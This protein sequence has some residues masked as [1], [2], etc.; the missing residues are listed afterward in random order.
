MRRKRRRSHILDI[1]AEGWRFAALVALVVPLLLLPVTARAGTPTSL[2]DGVDKRLIVGLDTPSL[3]ETLKKKDIAPKGM[4]SDVAM[5]RIQEI[6]EAQD[7]LATS[8][9]KVSPGAVVDH[10][11]Q[12]TLNGLSIRLSEPVNVAMPK[13]RQLSDV[14]YVYEETAYEPSLY[15]SVPFVEADEL[16]PA[17]GGEKQAGKGIKIAV[18]DSGIDINHPLF[19]PTSFS[20]PSGFPKGDERYTSPKV[21]AARTYFRPND[22]PLLGEETPVPGSLGS[23][24]GTHMAGIIAGQPVTATHWEREQELSGV[25]PAA[26]LLNYRIFYPSEKTEHEIAYTTEIL[27][28]IEDAV[29]DGADVL[30][31]S[32]SSVAPRAPFACPETEALEAA[33]DAGCVVV[34]PVGN[35]G[36]GQ[37]SASRIPGGMERAITVGGLGKDR[38]LARDFVDVTAPSPVPQELVQNPF[39]RAL[40]GPSID[41]P[42][43]PLPC[44]DVRRVDFSGSALACDS[45]PANSLIDHAVLISRGECPFADK[46]YHAQAAGAELAL[47]YNEEDRVEKMACGGEHCDPGE[48]TIPSLMVTRSVGEALLSRL[49]DHPDTTIR[50]D[51]YGRVISTT[52]NVVFTTSGRGPAYLRYLKPDLLAPGVSVLS[53]DHMATEG[54]TPYQQ[55]SGSSVACAHVAGVAAL[56]RQMHPQWSHDEIKAALMSTAQFSELYLDDARSEPAD[57]LD[58]GAGLVRAAESAEAS[59]F[60]SP[61]A[62]SVSELKPGETLSL[63]LTLHDARAEGNPRTYTA[64]ITQCSGISVTVPAEV[65]T[66]PGTD[67]EVEIAITVEEDCALGEHGL[68]VSYVGEKGRGSLPVWLHVTP[69]LEEASV[70]LID[71]DFSFFGQYTDYA[72]YVTEALDQTS[73]SYKVWNADEHFDKPQTIPGV[74]EL[75]RYDA[76]IWLTGDNVH[77][78]PYYAVS[79]P[80]TKADMHVLAAYL[81][82]GGRLLAMGQNLAQA[83]DINEEDDDPTWGRA[84][85]YHGY[86]GAHWLQQ[87]LFDPEGE[88]ALP[89]QDSPAVVGLPASF[90]GDAT[91]H[92][93]PKGDGAGNQTAID[94]IAPGGVPDGSDLDLIEP[95][96][97]ALQAQPVEAGYVG[98]AKADDPHLDDP[99][100]S[101]SYRSLYY[102]FGFEGINDTSDTTNRADF[103]SRSLDWLLDEIT[104]QL[105]DIRG[106]VNV[107][108]PV[109]CHAASTHSQIRS[110]RWRIEGKD[111]TRTTTSESP[112]ISCTWDEYG[113]YTVTVEAT[114]VLGHTAVARGK[115]RILAPIYLPLTLK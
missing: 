6:Q 83:T 91:L 86:L 106:N 109:T 81:D 87:S 24:H 49:E 4:G 9:A 58:R 93:G 5:E 52:E 27:A 79:V 56:L 28:A 90:L 61:P 37:G 64:S 96:L 46:V 1:V 84:D 74:S 60:F 45:L 73:L 101:L 78:D 98:L 111:G 38:I 71:N 47:I 113:T 23:G 107:P 34:A 57:I 63:S 29:T 19:D 85:F 82:G 7:A 69:R 72:P 70:L 115:A 15:A 99:V 80:L 16:W 108:I 97:M 31:N 40:F 75:Q 10:R 104:V 103:L 62:I 17:L 110:Y 25:A 51:P 43:G 112:S 26:Q 18:L 2:S 65:T 88:G 41:A 94:E 11:Y 3:L 33:M 77:P 12:V 55:M 20:Y 76:V 8:L 89:P 102:S 39:A 67:T 44:K 32:W 95:V 100:S 42:I 35:E 30:C 48:I 92:L 59:L 22:P 66:R 21:I 68:D 13:I 36:P 54:E 53:A 114:D 50:I 14:S 105:P